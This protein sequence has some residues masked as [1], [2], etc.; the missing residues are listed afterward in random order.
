MIQ[1]QC[2]LRLGSGGNLEP[3]RT[4]SVPLIRL[5]GLASENGVFGMILAHEWQLSVAS[6]IWAGTRGTSCPLLA[7]RPRLCLIPA[8]RA[9]EGSPAWRNARGIKRAAGRNDWG[10]VAAGGTSSRVRTLLPAGPHLSGAEVHFPSC[11]H[12]LPLLSPSQ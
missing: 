9:C 3:E 2:N 12:T 7:P 6:P 11:H 4:P 8:D 10:E 5:S 1:L